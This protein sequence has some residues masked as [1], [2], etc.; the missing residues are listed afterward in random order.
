L[1]TKF[2]LSARFK[3][4]IKKSKHHIGT[5]IDTLLKI[6]TLTPERGLSIPGHSKLRKMRVNIP[7]LSLGKSGGYRLIYRQAKV[8]EIRY[9]SMLEVYYKGDC[10]DLSKSE[11]Q[12][13]LSE[14][15]DILANYL[16]YEWR[17]APKILGM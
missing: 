12:T 6:L 9:I 5:Q 11:Y 2:H 8:D 3:R 10:E 7:K 1:D 14:S 16:D 4:S 13:L 15:D 17:D